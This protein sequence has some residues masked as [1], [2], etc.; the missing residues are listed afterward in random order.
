VVKLVDNLS[1]GVASHEAITPVD[2][3]YLIAGD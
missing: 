3:V 1:S 2:Q